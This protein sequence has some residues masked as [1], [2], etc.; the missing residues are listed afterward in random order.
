MRLA[1]EVLED[2]RPGWE[3]DLDDEAIVTDV[4][5]VVKYARLDAPPGHGGL[6]TASSA[7]TDGITFVGM[8]QMAQVMETR[9][10]TEAGS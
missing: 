7:H 1:T 9:G 4:A 6:L 5:V 3:L 2:I 8:L 10:W